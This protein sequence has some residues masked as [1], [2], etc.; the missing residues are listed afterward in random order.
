MLV[1][2]VKR[3]F[4]VEEFHR[5]GEAGIFHEDDRVELINGQIVQLSPIGRPHAYAVTMLTNL[6]ASRLAGRALVSP[7]NPV[8][9]FRDSE[10][11]P[12]I[13]LLRPRPDYRDVDVGPADVLLLVEVADSSLRYDR[14][15]KLRLY[16]RAGIPE[17]WIVDVVGSRVEVYRRPSERRYEQVE[18]FERGG[19]V[20]PAAFP[21]VAIAID[22]IL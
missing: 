7:Q 16:A 11:L 3:R 6:F 21:D 19:R 5:M 10:P 2:P 20:A 15:V 13:V 4:T 12:D 18:R 1:Q 17:V 14:L 22:E 9:L 8:H